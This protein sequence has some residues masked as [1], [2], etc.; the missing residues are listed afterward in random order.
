MKT[1][2]FIFRLTDADKEKLFENARNAG[3]PA[4]EYL[5][6]IINN[7]NPVRREDYILIKELINS[8]NAIGNNIN[9]IAKNFNSGFFDESEKTRLI[10]LMQELVSNT[11]QIIKDKK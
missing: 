11:E 1:E 10:K 7:R 3:I 6:G 2:T 8:T 5:R 4:A 9:Q